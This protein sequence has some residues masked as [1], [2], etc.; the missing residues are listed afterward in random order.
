MLQDL[1]RRSRW[2]DHITETSSVGRLACDRWRKCFNS[3]CDPMKHMK[4]VD[5]RFRFEERSRWADHIRE[6]SVGKHGKT[7][8][9]AYTPQY[10][11]YIHI[12]YN[13]LYAYTLTTYH[14]HTQTVSALNDM[15]EQVKQGWLNFWLLNLGTGWFGWFQSSESSKYFCL[16]SIRVRQLRHEITTQFWNLNQ[17]S[18]TRN[19]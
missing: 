1:K 9:H 5:S 15:L 10:I 8:C 17:K 16:A 7:L 13:T 6:T 14:S 3:D 19:D 2:V 4:M 18:G 11:H 12:A